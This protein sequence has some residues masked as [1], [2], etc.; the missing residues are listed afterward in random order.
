MQTESLPLIFIKL[1]YPFLT[2]EQGKI[3]N[4]YNNPNLEQH[5]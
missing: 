3:Q 1:I 2:N 5:C 4:I